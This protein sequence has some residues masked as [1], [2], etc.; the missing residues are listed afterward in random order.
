M[1]KVLL[2]LSAAALLIAAA[3]CSIA[4]STA[5]ITNATMTSAMADGIPADSVTSYPA[6]APELIAT[7]VL[8]NAPADTTVT[9]VWYY[10]GAEA[11]RVIVDA[12]GAS[13]VYV[14]STFV[15]NP[16]TVWPAGNYKVEIYIDERE[17]P[18]ATLEFTIE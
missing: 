6:D 18:D 1:K 10:E 13:G 16:G 17:K 8:N 14:Y 4:I 15:P 2:L 9:F 3:A 12:D 11:D 5:N 7:G